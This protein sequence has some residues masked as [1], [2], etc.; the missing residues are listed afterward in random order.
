M[1]VDIHPTG[2]LD[3][4]ARARRVRSPGP[5]ARII[6]GSLAAG[7]AAALVLT[8]V[9]FAGGTESVITGSVLAASGSAG[10]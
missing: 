1:S 2:H 10:R 7:A 6:A 4:T 5:V 3:D 8:L 9:V